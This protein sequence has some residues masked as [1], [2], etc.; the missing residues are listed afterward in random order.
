MI[1]VFLA[2]LLLA[3]AAP[4]ADAFAAPPEGYWLTEKK[5]V[6]VRIYDCDGALCGQTVWLKKMNQFSKTCAPP[7]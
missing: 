7:G 1:R 2:A 5:G 6:M 4:L 3:V